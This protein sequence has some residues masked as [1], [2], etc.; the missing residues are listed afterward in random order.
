LL[1]VIAASLTRQETN[2][3]GLFAKLAKSLCLY[4]KKILMILIRG[5]E[6]KH[7]GISPLFAGNPEASQE[8]RCEQLSG[9][10]H[11]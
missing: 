4:A 6:R 8:D 5:R 10:S 3:A 9:Q 2:L 7:F 11:A 1:I